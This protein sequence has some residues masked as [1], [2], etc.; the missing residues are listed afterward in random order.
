[1][2]KAEDCSCV[3]IDPSLRSTGVLLWDHGDMETY[4]IQRKEDRLQVLGYYVRHFAAL[5]KEKPWNFLCIED[6][7]FSSKGRAVT[8][9]AEIGGIIRSC[10]VARHVPVIEMPIQAWK[11]VTG[12]RL[13]K[14]TVRDRTE[15]INAVRS[16]TGLTAE[17]SDEADTFLIW[18]TL[19]KMS[20]GLDGTQ[21][22]PRLRCILESIGVQ[23]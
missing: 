8:G 20:R 23:L 5:A 7:S 16:V 14:K 18:H 15:Y 4:A 22:G 10:F 3:V 9:Q 21:A 12:L 11:K 17:T 2:I 13:S 19:V 6:Y 1:M